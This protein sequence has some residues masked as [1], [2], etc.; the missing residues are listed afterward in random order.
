MSTTDEDSI[1]TISPVLF[2]KDLGEA[3]QWLTKAFG[4]TER[5][6]ERVTLDNGQIVHA[7]LALGDGMIILSS[8]YDKFQVPAVDSVHHHCL[9]VAVEDAKAHKATSIGAGA[10]LVA[11]IRDTDYGAR[12]YSVTDVAGYHWIFAQTLGDTDDA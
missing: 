9:Y 7:E 10:T 4:F 12:V 2:Y 5:S 11:D 8:V 1:P 3:I 6:S